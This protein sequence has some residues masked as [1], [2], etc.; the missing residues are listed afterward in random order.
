MV[1]LYLYDFLSAHPVCLHLFFLSFVILKSQHRNIII[2]DYWLLLN[3]TF[4]TLFIGINT[5][6]APLRRSLSLYQ[7]QLTLCNRMLY[8][9]YVL[10]FWVL[11]WHAMLSSKLPFAKIA[12][13]MSVSRARASERTS[14][15]GRCLTRSNAKLC[16]TFPWSFSPWERVRERKMYNTECW[17]W[18]KYTPAR[19][20]P[21]AAPSPPMQLNSASK[22]LN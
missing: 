14:D 4:S 6:T 10:V 12:L 7:R 13:C 20:R 2:T 3:A 19:S 21:F 9:F 1:K 8:L 5:E 22:Y 17:T 15:E 18:F 11:N 16:T